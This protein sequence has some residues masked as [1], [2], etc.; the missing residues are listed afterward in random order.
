MDEKTIPKD[1]N[2]SLA[3]DRPLSPQLPTPAQLHSDSVEPLNDEAGHEQTLT[4]DWDEELIRRS[5][6][7]HIKSRGSEADRREVALVHKAG[8]ILKAL[9]QG[10]R[11]PSAA[12]AAHLGVEPGF[13]AFV[14]NGLVSLDEVYPK[15]RDQLAEAL[16]L[17]PRIVDLI[18]EPA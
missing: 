14:E 6:A 4:S 2:A 13:I 17:D 10:Q 8:V 18:F 7:L 11:I 5:Q 12:I 16:D 3:I 15:L 1:T 9:R